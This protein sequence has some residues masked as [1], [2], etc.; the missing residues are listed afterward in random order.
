MSQ[1]ITSH[2]VCGLPNQ[3][4]KLNK[5]LNVSL[6]D[7]FPAQRLVKGLAT[8]D[9]AL[10]ASFFVVCRCSCEKSHFKVVSKYVTVYGKTGHSAAC[11]NIEKRSIDFLK[12]VLFQAGGQVYYSGNDLSYHDKTWRAQYLDADNSV[13]AKKFF[14]KGAAL[15][16]FSCRRS[17]IMP[18]PFP[19]PLPTSH[20]PYL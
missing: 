12:N 4:G 17:H 2:I 19:S 5:L 15:S 20:K 9:Q 7:P 10:R 1:D 6:P 13:S 18:P 3:Q 8:R 16:R 11:V 14:S